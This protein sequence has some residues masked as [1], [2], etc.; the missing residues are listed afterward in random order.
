TVLE[1]INRLIELT[2]EGNDLLR[3]IFDRLPK[4]TAASV[5]REEEIE[6]GKKKSAAMLAA[7]GGAGAGAGAGA[8]DGEGGGLSLLET[9]LSWM[10]LDKLKS[11][12]KN[13]RGK[14]KVARFLA[15][16]ASTGGIK[17]ALKSALKGLRGTA[18]VAASLGA[19]FIGMEVA[20]ANEANEALDDLMKERE[21]AKGEALKELDAK[22]ETEMANVHEQEKDIT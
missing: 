17:G 16:V 7:A 20:E 13:W 19:A 9:L 5:K 10:G 6:A 2:E 18:W 3:D 22:I 15:A 8:G 21:T 12:W 14:R 11:M 4:P 1:G